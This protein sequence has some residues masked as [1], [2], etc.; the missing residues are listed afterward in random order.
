MLTRGL[1]FLPIFLLGFAPGPVLA[2]LTFVS[3]H[4]VF[5]HANVSWRFGPLEQL[6]VTPHFHHWHH[7]A[8]AP[9]IDKNFAVHLPWIDRLF[10][11]FHAPE[12]WPERYGTPGAAVPEGYGGQ[13]LHPFRRRR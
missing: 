2:Y 10:C 12:T 11:S 5:I 7:S 1:T 8:E 9:A 13:L 4:A 6:V 3:F